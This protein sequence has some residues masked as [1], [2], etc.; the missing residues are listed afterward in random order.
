VRD[1]V[2]RD[3]GAA[4]LAERARVVGVVAELRRQVEGDREAGLA[5]LEE[6][7]VPRVRLFGRRKAGVLPD[8]PRP[9]SVHVGVRPPGEGILTGQ[10]RSEERRVGKERESQWWPAPET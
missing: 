2:D 5:A 8:R 9:A 1:R 3:A 10:L 4:D 7:A 6:V